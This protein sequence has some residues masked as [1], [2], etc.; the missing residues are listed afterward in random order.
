MLKHLNFTLWLKYLSTQWGEDQ[1]SPEARKQLLEWYDSMAA[2][3]VN[4][5]QADGAT[6][7]MVRE[8]SKAVA[9][10]QLGFK[11]S[12]M[13]MQT[14][15]ITKGLARPS[16]KQALKVAF[17]M[18]RHPK[19]YFKQ[20]G[21]LSPFMA[22]RSES[23]EQMIAEE[24]DSQRKEKLLGGKNSNDNRSGAEKL[25]NKA[26]KIYGGYTHAAMAGMAA[27]DKYIAGL[28]WGAQYADAISKGL[29]SQ[30]AIYRADENVRKTQQSGHTLS[31]IGIQRQGDYSRAFTMFR[32]DFIKGYNQFVEVMDAWKNKEFSKDQAGDILG[33]IGAGV[34]AHM[35]GS[36]SLPRLDDWEDMLFSVQQSISSGAPVVGAGADLVTMILLDHAREWR[37]VPAQ[38]EQAYKRAVSSAL[39]PPAANVGESAGDAVTAFLRKRDLGSE[40]WGISMMGLPG[41]ATY[42]RARDNWELA[43]ATGKAKYMFLTKRAAQG[44]FERVR[45]AE[46]SRSENLN[47]WAQRKKKN[48][49]EE[50]LQEYEAWLD[51]KRE[52]G[53]EKR[54]ERRR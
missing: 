54:A 19:Q 5:K 46:R 39:L 15:S 45:K 51:F 17:S 50:K 7:N 38:G 34:I 27:I 43:D 36:W 4:Y 49:S 9:M 1:F 2:N 25:K 22:T 40:A 6:G 12:S 30:D 47:A 14:T 32:S 26:G 48:W 21:E 10:A 18:M 13:L 52:K 23:F 35:V 11:L 20:I 33:L 42:K 53:R 24:A 16:K 29:S 44:G 41:A 31:A 37:G 28:C 8:A 3:R